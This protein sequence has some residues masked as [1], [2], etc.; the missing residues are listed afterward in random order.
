MSMSILNDEASQLARA[1]QA[2]TGQRA[3]NFAAPPQGQRAPVPRQVFPEWQDM[4]QMQPPRPGAAQ[5]LDLSGYQPGMAQAQQAPSQGT[6]YNPSGGIS[7]WPL[8]SP[9]NPAPGQQPTRGEQYRPTS[10]GQIPNWA[11][12]LPFGGQANGIPPFQ[13]V[14]TDFMGGQYSDPSSMSAQQGAMAMALLQQRQGQIQRGQGLSTLDPQLAYRQGL[15]MLQNGWQNPFAEQPTVFQPPV[16]PRQDF[17]QQQQLLAALQQQSPRPQLPPPELRGGGRRNDMLAAG[18]SIDPDQDRLTAEFNARKQAEREA[19]SRPQPAP[20]PPGAAQPTIPPTDP[21]ISP[22]TPAPPLT[23]ADTGIRYE[24]FMPGFGNRSGWPR[25]SPQNPWEHPERG[26]HSTGARF[27]PEWQDM[28]QMQPHSP[29]PGVPAPPPGPARPPARSWQEIADDFYNPDPG[30][31]RGQ[32]TTRWYNP[33]TGEE[34][35]STGSVP[36]PGTGWVIDTREPAYGYPWMP[37]GRTRPAPP[38]GPPVPTEGRLAEQERW[39]AK[40]AIDP[41]WYQAARREREGTPPPVVGNR[42]GGLPTPPQTPMPL[43]PPGRAAPIT[44]SDNNVTYEGGK[45][46]E[47]LVYRNEKGGT[48]RQPLESVRRIQGM[49][50]EEKLRESKELERRKQEDDRRR[51]SYQW[52][53]PQSPPAPRSSK[54]AK[55]KK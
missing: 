37:I 2:R 35:E 16:F 9:F 15:E 32:V 28:S 47:F 27:F 54:P 30:A 38:P 40:Q 5:P 10:T 20:A 43:S 3:N 25:G 7:G 55:K 19:A 26:W 4:S 1:T 41:W 49:S 6:A 29:P 39:H 52:V 18:G 31:G 17:S 22:S 36:R 51:T 23:E 33:Q 34:F 44:P 48:V 12:Q 13:F 24:T 50:L 53:A 8:G 14:G 42:P 21:G 11:N 46:R 45:P